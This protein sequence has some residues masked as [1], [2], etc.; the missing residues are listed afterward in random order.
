MDDKELA[1]KMIN[2]S[3]LFHD[4]LKIGFKINL[5]GHNINH[6]ISILTITPTYPEFGIQIRF[7]IKIIKELSVL[8]A[9][10]INQNNFKNRTSFSD[11]FYKV[12]EEDQRN[13]ETDLI[14]NLNVYHI[15][16]ESDIDIIDVI[17]ELEYQIQNHETKE[18]G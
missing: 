15:L 11:T 6:A 2:P 13:N 4:N 1:K 9:R 12:I 17:F 14:I 18:S 16:T 5:E 8:Y 7:I 3:S 10:L